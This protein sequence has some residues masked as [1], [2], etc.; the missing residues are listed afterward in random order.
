MPLTRSII[1]LLTLFLSLASFT[2]HGCGGR[3]K[4]NNPEEAALK[5]QVESV[6]ADEEIV[7]DAIKASGRDVPQEAV[8]KS[9]QH[10]LQA[11]SKE[12]A[13]CD[14]FLA[15][16]R[17]AWEADITEK[18]PKVFAQLTERIKGAMGLCVLMATAMA[19]IH[20]LPE[21]A[22]PE[23]I[24]GVAN[25]FYNKELAKAENANFGK[26]LLEQ[27]KASL[28]KP[29]VLK[30]LREDLDLDE[31]IADLDIIAFKTAELEQI[32]PRVQAIS[33]KNGCF[34][35]QYE[36]HC[37]EAAREAEEELMA[38][39]GKAIAGITTTHAMK[40]AA[41]GLFTSTT[42]A[43]TPRPDPQHGNQAT[44]DV[45]SAITQAPSSALQIAES[46]KS[47]KKLPELSRAVF[48]SGAVAAVVAID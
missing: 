13:V 11:E 44:T 14:S 21:E 47:S 39:Q 41:S 4:G 27:G 38:D 43:K 35:Q 9:M 36:E 10:E 3:D 24:D 30:K 19:Q 32:F 34:L 1:T 37:K 26:N 8:Q 6:Q 12:A 17:Q 22:T 46:R 45:P 18:A 7:E 5:P 33:A 42:S 25:E 29:K 15:E 48:D 28:K 31:D 20:S 40:D 16:Q 23:L 2:L